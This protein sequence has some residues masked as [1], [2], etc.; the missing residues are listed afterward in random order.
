MDTRLE[1]TSDSQ[2]SSNTS[3]WKSSA[4]ELLV[5]LLGSL[6]N[7]NG[8]FLTFAALLGGLM[9]LGPS[10]GG[11][12]G[13]SPSDYSGPALQNTIL[14][15]LFFPGSLL[16]LALFQKP[17]LRVLPAFFFSL[18]AYLW[19]LVSLFF[20]LGL[21][22]VAKRWL[23][24]GDAFYSF[25]VGPSAGVALVVFWVAGGKIRTKKEAAGLAIG[26]LVG[27]GLY[28]AG[29]LKNMSQL[30]YGFPWIW[31]SITFFLELLDRQTGWQGIV[32]WVILMILAPFLN[33][34]MFH[35]IGSIHLF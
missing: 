14:A 16:I 2:L 26:F 11:W 12:L 10:T 7:I 6:L 32:L 24:P 3:A 8:V 4:I 22:S 5:V 18:L 28:T 27:I 13:G 33:N 19:G 29:N 34:T 15:V 17:K 9:S 25:I 23:L 20:I 30:A 1:T 31:L 21:I 35:L